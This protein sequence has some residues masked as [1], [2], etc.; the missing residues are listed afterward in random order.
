LSTNWPTNS[1]APTALLAGPHGLDQIR[2]TFGDIFQYVLPDH[3]L[4]PR[5]QTEFLSRITLP[6]PLTLSWDKSR[7]VT[8]MTCHKLLSGVFTEVF[9]SLHSVNAQ[10]KITSFGGCFNFRP[11]RTG[12]KLSAHSWGI[13]IDLNPEANAQGT[14]GDMDPGVIKIFRASGFEW[15]LVVGS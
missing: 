9:A 8:Q 3:T 11:Q 4:D 1:P 12:T 15:G 5:W 13:A 10:E 6:F 2:A 7:T 14:A